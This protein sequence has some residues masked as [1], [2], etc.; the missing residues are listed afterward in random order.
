VIIET[1]KQAEDR[2]GIIVR[3]YECDRTRGKIALHVG[4]PLQAAMVTNLIEADEMVLEVVDQTTILVSVKPFQ[5]LTI[6]LIP[7]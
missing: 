7:Q 5:I 3:L 6:R 2:R 1:I 4:L